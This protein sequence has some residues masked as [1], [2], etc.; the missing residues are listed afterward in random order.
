MK[1]V[2]D[3]CA[4]INLSIIEIAGKKIITY[5]KDFFEIY[6]PKIVAEKELPSTLHKM[7]T[8][9][10]ITEDE[11]LS[12]RYLIEHIKKEIV[13]E[14]SVLECIKVCKKWYTKSGY[15]KYPLG[16][17]ELS[18]LALALFLSRKEREHTLLVTDDLK[19]RYEQGLND[20]VIKQKIGIIYSTPDIILFLYG[21]KKEIKIV[22][23]LGALNDF[24]NFIKERTYI[25]EDYIKS[26]NLFCRNFGISEGICSLNCLR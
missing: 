25:K 18:C 13:P 26:I 11:E 19:A 9:G 14:S 23:V 5:V 10:E 24:F 1:C 17:G 16:K 4:L 7:V 6:I 3:T 8:R 21:R 2:I 20:F 15:Y 12:I 22:H